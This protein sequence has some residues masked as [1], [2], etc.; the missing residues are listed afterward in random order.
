[1]EQGTHPIAQKMFSIKDFFSKC[2]QIRTRIGNP[3][4]AFT[5]LRTRN[6]GYIKIRVSA[7]KT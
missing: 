5:V 1:M 3:L 2:D 7:C 4:K 6:W